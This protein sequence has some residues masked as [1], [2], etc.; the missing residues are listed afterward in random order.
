MSEQKY[1]TATRRTLLRAAGAGFGHMAFAGLLGA[2]PAKAADLN[3]L[4]PKPA[5]L[6]HD[7]GLD[8]SPH[9]SRADLAT[10]AGAISGPQNRPA[11]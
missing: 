2:Q 3:P 9:F 7:L 1:S 8:R 5:P 11:C 4:A 6:P 10:V